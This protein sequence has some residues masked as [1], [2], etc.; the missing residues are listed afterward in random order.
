[1]KSTIKCEEYKRNSP[2][3]KE[4]MALLLI[5]HNLLHGKVWEEFHQD[6]DHLV[7]KYLPYYEKGMREWW[8]SGKI[9]NN[10]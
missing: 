6:L 8:K 1:M 10:I 7:K 3:V 5:Q 2:D 9:N 4:L